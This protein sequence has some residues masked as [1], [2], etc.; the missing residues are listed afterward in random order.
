MITNKLG[1]TYS[2]TI[3]ASA[4]EAYVFYD[5]YIEQHHLKSAVTVHVKTNPQSYTTTSIADSLKRYL[6]IYL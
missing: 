2:D 6:C 3:Q 5:E 4:A 1:A